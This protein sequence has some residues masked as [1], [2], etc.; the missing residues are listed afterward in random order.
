M[1]R[2]HAPLVALVAATWLA[3]AGVGLLVW[4]A[5]HGPR[6]GPAIA[7]AVSLGAAVLAAG[8]V[9]QSRPR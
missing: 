1:Y 5:L 2:K 3:I 4:G 8:L 9:I 6:P 7:G